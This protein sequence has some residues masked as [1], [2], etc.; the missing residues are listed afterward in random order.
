MVL[1]F[2]HQVIFKSL[3]DSSGK[4][5][6]IFLTRGVGYVSMQ[7]EQNVICRKTHLDGTV[8]HK[9]TII[10]RQ[11]FAGHMVGSQPMRRK[12]KMHCIK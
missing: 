8:H 6:V 11:L 5:S 7:Y 2:D 1:S 4:R 12:E 10:C 3:S 9:Q